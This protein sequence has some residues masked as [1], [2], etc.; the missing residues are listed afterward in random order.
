MGEK[1]SRSAGPCPGSSESLNQFYLLLSPCVWPRGLVVRARHPGYVPTP[2]APPKSH[3]LDISL[4]SS[5]LPPL[6]NHLILT[7]DFFFCLLWSCGHPALSWCEPK[8]HL[9]TQYP[10]Y[11]L[12]AQ[13]NKKNTHAHTTKPELRQKFRTHY[14]LSRSQPRSESFSAT[15]S[16]FL[17]GFSWHESLTFCCKKGHKVP[18]VCVC[19]SLRN[20]T[21]GPHRLFNPRGCNPRTQRRQ[22]VAFNPT[23]LPRLSGK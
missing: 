9:G 8:T 22:S 20:V 7:A 16:Q 4:S 18:C 12:S 21:P 14:S 23:A 2:R 13:K 3:N 5:I 6:P 15:Q 11:Q 19:V 17:S 1:K 10:V